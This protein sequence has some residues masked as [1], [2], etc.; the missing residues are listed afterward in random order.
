[1]HWN[2]FLYNKTNQMHQFPKFAMA[3]NSPCFG[4]F[5]CPLSGVYSLYTRHW[6]VSYRFEDS[7]RTGPGWNIDSSMKL[8]VFQAVPLPIIRSLFT[9][10]SA[11]IYV[12]Q[13]WRQ[14][15]SRMR[16]ELPNL[17]WHETLHVLGSSCAQHQEFI[18]CSLGTGVCHTGLKIVFEQDQDGTPKFTPA[19]NSTCFGQFLCPSS[20]V[21]SLYT[22]HWYMSYLVLLE[23]CLQTCMTYTSA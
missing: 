4:Q 21:Y 20:G 10:H 2:K 7:F 17:L 6:Y 18:Y 15:L 5:L 13:V 9:V 14:L 1:V 11:L 22:R 23:S 19:W 12:I 16:M 3:W 8:Y